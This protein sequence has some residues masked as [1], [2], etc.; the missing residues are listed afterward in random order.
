MASSARVG[1]D[2][3]YCRVSHVI[4]N[5]ESL[6]F[7]ERLLGYPASD[8]DRHAPAALQCYSESRLRHPLRILP[9]AQVV[10]VHLK[11]EPLLEGAALAALTLDSARNRVHRNRRG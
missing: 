2:L 5:G 1:A 9:P 4:T 6:L 8:D 7:T 3:R 10:A 11:S